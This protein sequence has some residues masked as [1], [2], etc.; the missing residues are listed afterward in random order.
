MLKSAPIRIILG[1]LSAV[2]VFGLFSPFFV[3]LVFGISSDNFYYHWDGSKHVKFDRENRDDIFEGG[4]AKFVLMFLA[5]LIP[6]RPYDW[7]PPDSLSLQTDDD[8]A[9][10][11]LCHVF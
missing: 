10:L 8:C 6:L 2:A 7:G 11:I 1:L 5:L 9:C 4:P 3:Y